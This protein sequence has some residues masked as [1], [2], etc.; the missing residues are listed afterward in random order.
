MELQVCWIALKFSKKLAH[1]NSRELIKNL[2]SCFLLSNIFCQRGYNLK[3]VL[4]LYQYF[5]VF[6]INFN[7]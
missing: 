1:F 7:M 5:T 2:L 6:I 4:C 3:S